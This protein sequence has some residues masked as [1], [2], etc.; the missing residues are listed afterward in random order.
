MRSK[1]QIPPRGPGRGASILR[2]TVSSSGNFAAA[3]AHHT[4]EDRVTLTV[5]T[6]VL[7]P[8]KL[9]ERLAGYPHVRV[10]TVNRPDATNSHMAARREV[11]AELQRDDPGLVEIDQYD[12]PNLPE[13]YACRLAPELFTQ[14][15]G[16]LGMVFAAIGTGGLVNGLC[17]FRRR[18][19][20]TFRIVAVD[21]DGSCQA[22]P[23]RHGTV[24]RIS[25]YG[26]GRTTG[27]YREVADEIDL[28]EFV[29]D[30]DAVAMCHHQAWQDRLLGGSGGAVLAAVTQLATY[31]PWL[32]KC[33]GPVVA[34]LADGGEAYADT[35]YNPDWLRAQN[36]LTA[37]R[38][39]FIL[40]DGPLVRGQ[41][42][43]VRPIL[44]EADPVLN[45]GV[46]T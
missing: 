22:R 19:G 32:L 43:P 30:E 18:M 21:A 16:R 4:V 33:H 27:L 23:P 2:M 17:R 14:T 39:P 25:G 34:I 5:V 15:G 11:I 40:P 1:G 46:L 28:Y 29:R 8:R 20:L 9:R 26:N 3:V 42:S 38:R 24:R 31:R 45:G 12:N 36:L 44:P 35:L 13:G 7:S 37:V 6:D 41:L 10:I